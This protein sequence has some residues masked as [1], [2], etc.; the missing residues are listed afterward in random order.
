MIL[1]RPTYWSRQQEI[2]RAVAEADTVAVPT[3]NAVGKS[4]LAAGLVL[5]WL[6]TRP[7]SLVIATAPSQTLLGTVLF[8]EISRAHARSV[9]PLGGSISKSPHVSPQVLRL[10]QEGWQC[11]G[12]ATRGV[13]R[14]SG[15]HATDLLVVVDE[16]SAIEGEIWE[17]IRSLNPSRLVVFGN[18]LRPDGEFA[19]L[20]ARQDGSARVIRIP[21]TESPDAQIWRSPRGLADAA[22]LAS[23]ER[24][25]GKDSLWWQTHIEARFPSAAHDSLLPPHWVDRCVQVQRA[26]V[27]RGERVLAAD[28]SAGTGRDRCVLLVRDDLGIVEIVSSAYIDV[29]NAADQIVRLARRHGVRDDHVY[30]DAGG[31]GRDLERYLSHYRF[32]ACIP[33]VGSASGGARFANARSRAAWWMRQR[34]D[35]GRPEEYR[36]PIDDHACIPTRPVAQP[37]QAVQPPFAVEAGPFWPSLREELLGLRY[38]LEGPQIALERKDAY[39]ARIGR[40]PDHADALIMS[41]A[42]GET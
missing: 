4:F 1:G 6:Y 21:S 14:L 23:A 42:G 8:K 41:F 35:P 27:D 37:E 9:I 20:C 5:W 26:S 12:I 25:Y 15:Q 11:L 19:R 32:T 33:Y 22:F 28:L 16:A 39:A 38:R 3:G 29:S 13:E 24:D 7:G 40:S 34:L 2:C 18:P 10:D 36:S 17:A 30:Y 31:P